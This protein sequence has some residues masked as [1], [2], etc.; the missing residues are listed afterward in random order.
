[1]SFLRYRIMN[2]VFVPAILGIVI[3][4]SGIFAFTP[5]EQASTS[6]VTVQTDAVDLVEISSAVCNI[7]GAAT[8]DLTIDLDNGV[9]GYLL[10][11]EIDHTD[12]GT[13]GQD[14]VPTFAAITIQTVAGTDP[15]DNAD[16]TT[17]LGQTIIGAAGNDITLNVGT[18]GEFDDGDTVEFILRML[19][20]ADDAANT[21]VAP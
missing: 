5:V 10:S 19:I 1:M 14:D 9:S 3:L 20:S 21:T 4:I 11:F 2:R 7:T 15:A 12:G 6:H 16:S 18:A 8:C 13:Q 17:R